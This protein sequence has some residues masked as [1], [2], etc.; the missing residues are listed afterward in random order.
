MTSGTLPPLPKE[1]EAFV[2]TPYGGL[3]GNTVLAH[4]IEELVAS[5]SVIYRPKDLEELTGRA[6]GSI[7]SALATLHRLK[8]IE[9]LSPDG[10]HP[11]YRVNTGSKKFVALSFLA[12]AMLD[13]RDG[14]DCMDL[15][16][17]HYYSMYLRPEYEPLVYSYD[18]SEAI[19]EI[20]R[21]ISRTESTTERY[22]QV[23]A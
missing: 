1:L 15:A 4:V 10:P 11:R 8:L 23:T 6:E 12:Y 14:S 21:S 17:H 9:N 16:V 5:P 22:M 20:A 3:F 7:R 13:D 19:E 2:D 18:I